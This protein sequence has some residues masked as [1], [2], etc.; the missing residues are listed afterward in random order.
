MSSCRE[1]RRRPF[2]HFFVCVWF[3]PWTK[4]HWLLDFV[5]LCLCAHTTV[6]LDC[7]GHLYQGRETWVEWTRDIDI[8]HWSPGYCGW[9][10][11]RSSASVVFIDM[12]NGGGRAVQFLFL[13]PWKKLK[14]ELS[15][16]TL[17]FPYFHLIIELSWVT[18][19]LLVLHWSGLPLFCALSCISQLIDHGSCCFCGH[20][21]LLL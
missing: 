20:I 15:R 11:R 13:F 3:S 17:F 16:K 14:K 9:T 6:E 19:T 1:E 2:S 12:P 4:K 10:R 18:L 21:L 8:L 5:L 7:T